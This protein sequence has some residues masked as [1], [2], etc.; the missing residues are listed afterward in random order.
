M[1]ESLITDRSRAFRSDDRPVLA[2]LLLAA[3][4]RGGSPGTAGLSGCP[5]AWVAL[6]ET[7]VWPGWAAGGSRFHRTSPRQRASPSKEDDYK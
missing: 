4:G 7:A 2:P 5:V 6:G 3:G 1:S